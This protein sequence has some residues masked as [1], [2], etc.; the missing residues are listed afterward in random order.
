M[1]INHLLNLEDLTGINA[2]CMY[3]VYRLYADNARRRSMRDH[4]S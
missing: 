4:G 1:I 3:H 2:S